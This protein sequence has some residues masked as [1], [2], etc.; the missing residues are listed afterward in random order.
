M[1]I[2]FVSTACLREKKKKV[3]GGQ[4]KVREQDGVF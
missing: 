3:K 2:F 1:S 4:K